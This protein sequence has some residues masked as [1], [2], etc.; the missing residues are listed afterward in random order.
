MKGKRIIIVGGGIAGSALA[1]KLIEQGAEIK[2]IE[3]REKHQLDEGLFMG[4]SPNGLNILNQLVD[5]SKIYDNYSSGTLHFFNA[6]GKRIACLDT[7]YQRE[8][9]GIE[10]IQIKRSAITRLLHNKLTS[11]GCS[12]EY[13]CQLNSI[14]ITGKKISVNTTMGEISDFD[15][16]IG[17]D[18]IHSKCRDIVF[19][20]RPKPVY[21]GQISTGAIVSI[22]HWEDKTGAINMTFGKRAF[23]A[24]ATSNKGEIWWFNNFYRRLE[25]DGKKIASTLQREIITELLELH[26]GDDRKISEILMASGNVFAYPVYE[27]PRLEKWHT[28]NICLIG[29]AAHAVSPHTGQGASL[30][31]EDSAVL[32]KCLAKYPESGLAFSTFQALREKR[33]KEIIVQARKIGKSKSRPNPIS[34]FFRDVFLKYFIN[35]EKK[36][37]DWVYAYNVDDL[38]I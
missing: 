22:P 21:T 2:I 15:L 17:A 25:P 5:I 30:A 7:S 16:L 32:A 35:L 33:V 29:D 24:F 28:E 37:L 4:M 31:L 13:G 6:R 34:T 9:Y 36:K 1:I 18:G 8:Q 10:S 11:L 27:V 3:R 23:F 14:D 12:L 26:K 20:N 19:P 38:R